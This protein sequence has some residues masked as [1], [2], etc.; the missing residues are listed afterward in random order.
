[1][2]WRT[3]DFEKARSH[4]ETAL[5]LH[6]R[7]LDADHPTV[8]MS[9][10]GLAWSL[11]SLGRFSEAAPLHE[12]ALEISE[13]SFGRET[14]EV[15]RV[16]YSQG[17]LLSQAGR[18]T[19]ARQLL[20]K[21]LAI[22][23]RTL[24]PEHSA[25]GWTCG[26]LG[27]ALLALDD[28]VGARH[29][30][31]RALEILERD[32]AAAR[33][34]LERTARIREEVFGRD[35]PILAS[36]FFDLGRLERDAGELGA[37]RL[38]FERALQI[39][40]RT[41]GAE[42]H[43]VS[44][45]L[46]ELAQIT[47]GKEILERQ[48]LWWKGPCGSPTEPSAVITSTSHTRSRSWPGFHHAKGDRETA[49]RLFEQALALQERHLEPG[50]RRLAWSFDSLGLL[51]LEE[52]RLERARELL[53]QSVAIRERVYS[54]DHLLTAES[55]ILLADLE[56]RSGDL[57]AAR[58]LYQRVIAIRE[59][60]LP[61]GHPD[62]SD[63]YERAGGLL[64]EAPEEVEMEAENAKARATELLTRL[65]DGR[66]GAEE[67]AP[68]VYH[69]LRRLARGYLAGERRPHP[70]GHR[71]G[72]RGLSAAGRRDP[73]GL[74]R[75]HPFSCRWRARHATGAGRP[76]S[77]SRA[78]QARGRSAPGH[79]RRG[80]PAWSVTPSAA[81]RSSPSTRPSRSCHSGTRARRRSSSSV[82]SPD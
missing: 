1:M 79:S 46:T 55:L 12:R 60:R 32:Y 48:P 29:T 68:L 77:P 19:E 14:A 71:P 62:L 30:A 41:L 49:R 75:P 43:L 69:E 52:G 37:A 45:V 35:H 25:V 9:L 78:R 54:P 64:L 24:G 34:A 4:F 23:E 81:K 82:F 21:A 73:G 13:R 11:V 59:A 80:G 16:L 61:A 53:E 76:R 18:Y 20:E 3:G 70:R 27:R 7:V 39:R 28:F 67:L 47:C 6:E 57:E 44:P 72:A 40:E 50:D 63:A 5:A 22:Q 42:H 2:Y 36:S 51:A 56:R 66:A 33:P 65:G 58:E 15:A 10:D 74:A 26:A 31:Q 38:A 17:I 8:A